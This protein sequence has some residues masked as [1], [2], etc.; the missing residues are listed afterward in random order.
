MGLSQST[1]VKN[2]NVEI[3]SIDH[4]TLV[5]NIENIFNSS[6]STVQGTE[7]T[8]ENMRMSST[9][10][11]DVS[12]VRP[13]TGGSVSQGITYNRNR[14]QKFEDKFLPLNGGASK[15]ESLMPQDN[16]N[17]QANNASNNTNNTNN[18]TNSTRE[19]LSKQLKEIIDD[20]NKSEQPNE[21]DQIGGALMSI[22]EEIEKTRAFLN[23]KPNNKQSVGAGVDTHMDSELKIMRDSLLNNN[24]NYSATSENPIELSP[25]N[26]G[27]G[28]G[29]GVIG[30]FNFSATS[31][32]P[33][34]IDSLNGGGWGNKKNKKS[35]KSTKSKSKNVVTSEL[36]GGEELFGELNDSLGKTTDDSSSSSSSNSSTSTSSSSDS[37]SSDF[38]Y[39][40]NDKITG[41]E[42]G[43]LQRSINKR[44]NRSNFLRGEYVITSNSDN[45]YVDGRP[46]YSSQVSE[47]KNDVASEYLN[48][49]RSRNRS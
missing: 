6:N 42:M 36:S 9:S 3:K 16:Q 11:V 19:E 35:T 26:G 40:D 32:N 7:L 43:A 15:S 25:L 41:S 33:I 22:D 45:N 1:P 31:E 47:F 14:Y 13:L 5:R 29:V 44:Q 37:S 49:L 10:D 18:A 30:D 46:Y 2:T 38:G 23:M 20:A 8:F 48:K 12:T 4:D 34:N 24:N 28:N 27:N 21:D 39:G 17:N